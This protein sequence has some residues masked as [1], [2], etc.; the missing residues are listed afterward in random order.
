MNMMKRRSVKYILFCVKL[1]NISS[2]M[3]ILIKMEITKRVNYFDQVLVH[4]VSDIFNELSEHRP[5][6]VSAKITA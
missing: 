3:N 5:P 2:I 1:P 6:I 4:Q